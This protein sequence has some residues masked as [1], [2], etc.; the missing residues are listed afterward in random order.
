M[1]WMVDFGALRKNDVGIVLGVFGRR[2]FG[3]RSEAR[4]TAQSWVVEDPKR[5][6][7]GRE[8]QERSFRQGRPWLT[9]ATLRAISYCGL[10]RGLSN[11]L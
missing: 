10:L 3:K 11:A 2:A 4:D 1:T 5:R 8:I 7:A 6:Q 9:K